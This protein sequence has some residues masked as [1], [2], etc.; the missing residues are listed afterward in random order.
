M[1]SENVSSGEISSV[2]MPSFIFDQQEVESIRNGLSGK[3]KIST[4]LMDKIKND[5]LFRE[6]SIVMFFPM[7][8]ERIQTTNEVPKI[9]GLKTG[10][11]DMAIKVGFGEESYVIKRT[12]NDQE[13]VIA[14]LM[15]EIGVGPKQFESIDGYITEEFIKGSTINGIVKDEY[16]PEYMEELGQKIAT[17]IELVHDKNILINDQ[18]LVDD[19]GKSH[20]IVTP[21]GGI[22]FIDFGAAVDLTNYP[23]ISDEAVRLIIRSDAFAAMGL[24]STP[25]EQEYIKSYREN[26][27]GKLKTKKEVIDRFDGRLLQEGLYF[28]SK[29]LPNVGHLINGYRNI[30]K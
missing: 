8:S 1:E 25:E 19:N 28:L 20:T 3:E 18:L 4:D 16:T 5:P 11:R 17:A 13:P 10:A 26:V 6:C 24:D 29:K 30:A 23:D 15:A 9:E 12:E 2:K 14:K 21:E 7:I 27:L 22:R